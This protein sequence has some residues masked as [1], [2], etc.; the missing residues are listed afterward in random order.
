MPENFWEYAA[1]R[2]RSFAFRDIDDSFEEKSIGW[3]SVHNMFDSSFTYASYAA[4][5]YIVLAL[6]IDERKVSAAV[7]KKFCLKEEERIK[8]EKELPRLSRGHRQEIK[9]SVKLMLLKKAL[10][11]PSVYDLFWNLSDST[12]YFFSTNKKAQEILENF[13]KETFN[14]TLTLQIPYLNA[15]H[16]VDEE[17]RSALKELGADIFI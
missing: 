13:F 5:D 11:T 4:G 6:R 1:E 12:L 7:L 14:L 10:P 2:I 8:K 9:E 16:L 3:V 15:E 17:G